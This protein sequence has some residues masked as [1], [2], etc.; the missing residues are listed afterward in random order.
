M[1]PLKNYINK[2]YLSLHNLF[3]LSETNININV[4][5]SFKYDD[6]VH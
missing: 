4:L 2:Y 6:K 3:T 5:L 1:K